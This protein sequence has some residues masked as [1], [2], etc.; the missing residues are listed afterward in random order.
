MENLLYEKIND[1]IGILKI[2]RAKYMNSL[3]RNTLTELNILLDEIEAD[4]NLHVLIISGE[5]EKAFVAG[6]DINQMKDMGC[7]EAMRFSK[8]GN[9]V[10]KKIE[11]LQ[12]V[13]IAA[14]NGYCLGGGLELAL[15]CDIRI[16]NEKSKFAQP[17]VGL[18]II[19]GFGATQRLS[20]VIGIS[21]AKEMIYTGNMIDS[22][23]ALS[24]GILNK[25]EEDPIK[26]SIEMANK[27]IKKAPIA[28]KQAKKAINFAYNKNLYTDYEV[29]C[30]AS[31][32]STSDQ[33][34]GMVA[35]DEKRKPNFENK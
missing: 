7:V 34:E 17:E 1:N 19:P 15:A 18:G 24:L 25:I 14:I 35:F 10:F 5:G 13:V 20:N 2:N 32:F 8:L 3:N 6:A 28:V 21:K 4:K 11:N 30:F 31:C 12:M 33:K 27:I 29:E 9:N 16:G 26:E 23:E 22:K